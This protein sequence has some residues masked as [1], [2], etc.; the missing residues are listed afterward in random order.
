[1]TQTT[2]RE[3]LINGAVASVVRRVRWRRRSEHGGAGT[4]VGV[5]ALVLFFVAMIA[6]IAVLTFSVK[7]YGHSMEPTLDNGDRLFT[8][9]FGRSDVKR[10]DL[11][12]SEAGKDGMEVVKRVIGMPGDTVGIRGGDEPRVYVRPDGSDTTYVVDNPAWPSR[13]GTRRQSCC[14]DQGQ[15][16][17][18]SGKPRWITLGSSTYWLLG[19][20][21]GGSDDSRV[22]G[23]VTEDLI[24][25]TLNFRIFPLSR[26]GRLNQPV[27]LTPAPDVTPG[28]AS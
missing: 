6:V 5:I 25:S 23:T 7:V 2:P 16:L 1:M 19:D 11:V 20:N 27:T 21:W 10:F 4:V 13:W 26:I 8:N 14:T 28:P 22:W 12:Q 18:E 24:S 17:S 3:V 9:V 15:A